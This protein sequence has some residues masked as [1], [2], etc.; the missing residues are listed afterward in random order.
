[1][2]PV[3]DKL[4]SVKS[5]YYR[6]AK[7]LGT[8][9]KFDRF[10]LIPQHDGGPHAECESEELIF[11]YTERGKRYGERRTTDPDEL[12]YWFVSDLTWVMA[13]DYEIT[14]R[15]ENEDSRRVLFAKHLELLASIDP[16]WAERKKI[17]YDTILLEHPYND[18]F[19]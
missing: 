5:K 11:V 18:K 6:I 7:Q 15:I 2:S 4:A 17:E 12:L 14:H 16:A 10:A 13:C 9:S 1:M 8:P 19:D 3:K